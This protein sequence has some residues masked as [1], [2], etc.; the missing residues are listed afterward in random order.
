MITSYVEK[1]RKCLTTFILIGLIG[2]LVLAIII[3]FAKDSSI[4]HYSINWLNL[5]TF[6]SDLNRLIPGILV[7]L[8]SLVFYI[9][10]ILLFLSIVNLTK[11]YS[12]KYIIDKATKQSIATCS[13]LIVLFLLS[14]I[15][16]IIPI[17]RELMVPLKIGDKEIAEFYINNI[18]NFYLTLLL[19]IPTLILSIINYFMC[20]NIPD[21]GYDGNEDIP[22]KVYDKIVKIEKS[23]LVPEKSDDI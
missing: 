23:L 20:D 21:K 16:K 7:F 8:N 19:S 17:K 1:K 22:D 6:S 3:P 9:Y 14:F 18:S 11:S 5:L 13:A 2:T 15:L 4:P 10:L 12:K